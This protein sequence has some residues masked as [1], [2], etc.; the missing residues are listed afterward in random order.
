MASNPSDLTVLPASASK[1]S[2]G[3]EV[4]VDSLGSLRKSLIHAHTQERER[5]RGGRG[6]EGQKRDSA[7]GVTRLQLQ[8]LCVTGLCGLSS[9]TCLN[10]SKMFAFA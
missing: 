2:N 4:L 10:L 6:R 9:A 8:G 3:I 1:Q 7:F 5:E